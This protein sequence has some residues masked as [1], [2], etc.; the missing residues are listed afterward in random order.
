MGKAATRRTP[1]EL[2][3]PT[4]RV[5][6]FGMARVL[7]GRSHVDL[8]LPAKTT[9]EGVVDALAR[10][11]P[12][13]VGPVISSDGA[14]LLLSYTLNLNGESF[15]ADLPITLRRGDSLLLFSSQA[16]G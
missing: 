10:A 9:E 7:S 16:G 3:A 2:D 14:G 6:L 15:V 8:A 13:L 12:E 1:A 11:C 5:E 4:V